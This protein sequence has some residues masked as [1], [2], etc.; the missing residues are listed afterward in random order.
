MEMQQVTHLSIT[1]HSN[2]ICIDNKQDTQKD[3]TLEASIN[4]LTLIPE[5][6]NMYV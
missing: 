5:F 6:V 4:H 2:Y 3:M 1:P